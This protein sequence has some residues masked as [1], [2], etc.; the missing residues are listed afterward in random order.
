L[1]EER[2]ANIREF[3]KEFK[4]SMVSGRGLD[5]IP[6]RGTM[7]ALADLGLTKNNLREEILAL[8]VEDYCGGPEPD[9]DR[10]GDVWIFGKQIFGREIYI[11]LKIAWVGEEKIAKCLSFHPAS[12]PLCFPYRAKKR[13]DDT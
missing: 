4:K 9:R 3:L 1:H 11:K 6:R 13:R 12:Y 2:E 8:S 7:E 5:I 10:T